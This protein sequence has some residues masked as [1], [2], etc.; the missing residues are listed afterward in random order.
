MQL[1]LR[2]FILFLTACALL[3]YSQLAVGPLL[4]F[5]VWLQMSVLLF[6]HPL[7]KRMQLSAF[8][9]FLISAPTLFFWGAVHSFVHI[10]MNE[11]Q[12]L[13]LLMAASASFCLS[14][15]LNLLVSFPFLYLTDSIGASGALQETFNQIKQQRSLYFKSSLLLFLCSFFS[16]V[17]ADWSLILSVMVTHLYLNRHRL[18]TAIVNF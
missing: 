16:L 11:A 6:G 5:A 10:Y 14:F 15:L 3:A 17:P 2:H 18:K 12:L 9:L 13:F 4:A 8:M 1:K 7:T